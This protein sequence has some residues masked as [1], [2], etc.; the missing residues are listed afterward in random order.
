[1]EV[2]SRSYN[3]VTSDPLDFFTYLKG[4]NEKLYLKVFDLIVFEEVANEYFR[5]RKLYQIDSWDLKT[6][7]DV[8]LLWWIYCLLRP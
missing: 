7:R 5:L 8:D 1:M 3:A 6:K 2:L 4:Q